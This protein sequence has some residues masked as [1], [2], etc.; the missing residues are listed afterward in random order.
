MALPISWLILIPMVLYILGILCCGVYYGMERLPRRSTKKA[1]IY[2]CS[3]C[4]AVYVD[5]R[6]VPLTRCPHCRCLNEAIKR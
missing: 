6:K 2:R 3:E 1:N 5:L 4:K